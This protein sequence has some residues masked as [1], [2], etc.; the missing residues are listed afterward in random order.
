MI[1]FVGMRKNWFLYKNKDGAI[2]ALA[3]RY[4]NQPPKVLKISCDYIGLQNAY[5]GVWGELFTRASFLMGQ[6]R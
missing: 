3:Q 6:S 4:D 5:T 1:R 2:L